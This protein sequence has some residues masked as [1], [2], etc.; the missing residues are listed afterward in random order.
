MELVYSLQGWL[1][2]T[3]YLLLILACL[4]YVNNQGKGFLVASFSITL[5][6]SLLIEIG[7]LDSV[8]DSFLAV[9][10]Y[11]AWVGLLDIIGSLISGVLLVV[12]WSN[13]MYQQTDNDSRQQG[14]TQRL[15]I[16]FKGKALAF[17]AIILFVIPA[18]FF[19]V[20]VLAPDYSSVFLS[21]SFGAIYMVIAIYYLL[22]NRLFINGNQYYKASVFFAASFIVIA[23]GS[24]VQFGI[25]N[26]LPVDRI[27]NPMV[28]F[29]S[30]SQ[31]F[32][33]FV[34]LHLMLL[35][36]GV[37]ELTLK[38]SNKTNPLSYSTEPSS[39]S[40][41]AFKTV[42]RTRLGRLWLYL[43]LQFVGVVLTFLGLMMMIEFFPSSTL[44]LIAISAGVISFIAAQVYF[45][46]LLYRIWR[47]VIQTSAPLNITPSINSPAK[48]VGF[49]FIPIFSL[50]WIFIAIGKLTTDINKLSEKQQGLQVVGG[51]GVVYCIIGLLGL[52]PIVGYIFTGV[53]LIVV[54]PVLL[55]QLISAVQGNSCEDN[56]DKDSLT[57]HS[58]AHT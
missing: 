49:L 32:F 37:S 54:G 46:M 23:V 36:L 18:A 43:T 20:A 56:S 14:F 22:S 33:F 42:S 50:Y 52:I 17:N 34:M 55:H 13:I 25:Q 15:S 19:L 28:I 21:F 24:F 30:A 12:A 41:A 7:K 47:H 45:L 29:V 31:V 16:G 53:G 27:D 10:E 40:I 38:K 51:L 11:F 3:V 1:A 35:A 26:F 4:L 9:E 6:M 44:L 5:L 58:T 48:A 8:R 2:P 57:V 39:L